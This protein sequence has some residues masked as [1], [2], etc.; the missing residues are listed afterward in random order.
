M[1]GRRENHN[2]TEISQ[3]CSREKGIKINCVWRQ[4]IPGHGIRKETSQKTQIKRVVR[5]REREREKERELICLKNDGRTRC[6]IARDAEFARR[7]EAS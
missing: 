4:Q 2:W 3:V 6:A 7:A 1:L 5:E